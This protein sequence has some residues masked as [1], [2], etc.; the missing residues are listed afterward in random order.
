MKENNVPSLFKINAIG[1]ICASLAYSMPMIAQTTD[2]T[3]ETS[4]SLSLDEI[5]VTGRKREESLQDI[6]VSISVLGSDLLA[7]QN[8]LSQDDLAELVP[9]L[10]YNQGNGR[11]DDRIAALPSIRG[12]SSNEIATNRT[13]VSSFV[14]GMPILGSVGAI[15]IGGATQVEVYSGPQSA[16]FGRSTFAGA[17]NYVTADP[18]DE[19]GGTLGVNWSNEGTRIVSGSVGGPITETLGFHI[20]ASIEDSVSPDSD[21]YSYTDGVESG[22]RG[23]NN[24][25]ARFVFQ[26]T[27]AFTAKLTFSHDETDDGPTSSFYATQESSVACFESLSDTYALQPAMGPATIGI[28]GELDCELDRDPNATLLA[29]NDIERYYEQNPA[30]L[31]ALVADLEAQGATDGAIGDYT[32]EEAALLIAAGYSVPFSDVGSQSERDRVSAQFDYLF[33]NGSAIQ[34]SL[35]TSE[36]E[37]IR[38][39]SPINDAFPLTIAFNGT[40]MDLGGMGGVEAYNGYYY[41]GLTDIDGDPVAGMAFAEG[42]PTDIEENYMELRW[43][44]P[45]EE[46]LRYVVGASYYDYS[47]ITNIYRDGG[48]GALANGT[49]DELEAL[50]NFPVELSALIS[51]KTENTAIFFNASYD[52]TDK[53][54]ASIEGRYS[55]DDV[56]AFSQDNS[57]SQ[58][59]KTF[60]PRIGINYTPSDNTTYYFQYAVGVNP[61]GVSA[62]LLDPEAQATLADGLVV[63]LNGDGDFDD[64]DED[65]YVSVNYDLDDYLTFDEEKLTNFEF[66]FKGSALD[67]RLT[68]TGAIYHMIWEDALQT[69]NLDWD[70]TYATNNAAL[71]GTATG[72]F[73]TLSDGSEIEAYYYDS[74]A[75]T[76]SLRSSS[77]AGTSETTGIELQASYQISPS[78]SINGN[79]S[80]MKA[81]YTDYCSSTDYSGNEDVGFEAGLTVSQDDNGNDCY[82]LDGYELANQP[83]FTMSLTPSYRTELD[84]G[85]RF[86][87]SMRINHNGEQNADIAGLQKIPATTTFNLT[88]G[89]ARDSWSGTFYVENL[90]DDR[91]ITDATFVQAATYIDRY[92]DTLDSS[93]YITLGTTDYSSLSYRIN[94]G[95]S[96]GLRLNY[97]F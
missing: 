56:G 87:G 49:A 74:S 16:A 13:K 19:L 93:Q 23:G 52:L 20:G 43:A 58:T 11:I 6:P 30:A 76:T 48:Y 38:Q 53:I 95:R 5:V 1:L 70:Y 80:I 36:E 41:Y 82:V 73:I 91:S 92:G 7:E 96:Y 14:D 85:M 84:N 90:L 64:L 62:N 34:L 12:I 28:R 75:L 81:E 79:T 4:S 55:S 42:D 69:V 15:N 63:D 32:V 45:A 3:E 40:G 94:E 71:I 21:V 27:D 60:V 39:Q 26:P 54:T 61:A 22:T 57:E 17:I 8:V 77:N 2:E 47:F 72:E 86:N 88:L 97:N 44:S 83:S 25:S 24:L 67:N 89:L 9:G 68:Y 33:D 37:Y 31:A 10:N 66:G 51:E 35:M 18:A 50:T 59:T 65:G 78:W 46:R 29:V